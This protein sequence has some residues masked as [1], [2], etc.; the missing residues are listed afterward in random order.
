MN[1]AGIVERVADCWA[2][3]HQPSAVSKMHETKQLAE[4]AAVKIWVDGRMEY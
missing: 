1:N 2:L 3:S 4:P